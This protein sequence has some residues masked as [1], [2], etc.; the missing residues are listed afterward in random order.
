MEKSDKPEQ[1]KTKSTNI[2]TFNVPF[3]L[4]ETKENITTSTP[5]NLSNEEIINQAFKFH[6]QGNI[7]EAKKYYQHYIRQGFN[8]HRVFSNY[9][10]I[11]HGYGKLKEAE[12]SYRKAIKLK[13]DFADAH[14]NL[15]T[16]FRDTGRFKEAENSYRK[17]IT[18]EPDH[19]MSYFNLGMMLQ[20][21]DELKEAELLTRKAI[22]IK[23]NFADAYIN[24]GGI[25]KDLGRSKE[26][27]ISIRKAIEIKPDLAIAY[28][29]LANILSGLGRLKEAEMSTRR[30]IEIQPDLSIAHNNLGLI[31][32][33]LGRLQEAEKSILKAIDLN[34]MS[35]SIKNNL[36]DLLTIYKPR[37]NNL[38]HLYIINEEYQKIKLPSNKNEIITDPE[39]IKI[40]QNGLEIYRRNSLD[41]EISSSQIYKK[42]N[43]NFDCKRHKLIFE[44][45][46]VI[47]EF[48][49]GCY[50]VQVEVDSVIELIKLF[51]VFNNLN[52]QNKNTRKCMI[53]CRNYTSG[54]YKGLIYCLGLEEALEI[55]KHLNIQIQNNIRNNLFSKVKRGCTEYSLVFP[56]YKEISIN[57]EQKMSY[58]KNWKRIEEKI[59]KENKDWGEFGR[60]IEGFNLNNFLIMRNWIAYAQKI[61]DPSVNRI[62][63]EYIKGPKI[64]NSLKRTFSNKK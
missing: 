3:N 15:G 27:E 47:P 18:I 51:L 36:I 41:I 33:S 46:K 49:F 22:E 55:S 16:I 44:Q 4:G 21:L 8:D 43:I 20:G 58:N 37:E 26:A 6:S 17:A 28:I 52:L 11:L 59:D 7:S 24:L 30:A 50:K 64:I 57:G 29:S 60:S 63:N 23:P 19:T 40:Y 62:T 38:S 35:K 32:K 53:E 1:R 48:C 12:I 13:D 5:F 45:H 25:L 14:Y 10:V 2:K 54:F 61:G 34:P 39:A 56:E 42:Y 31:L 9:G